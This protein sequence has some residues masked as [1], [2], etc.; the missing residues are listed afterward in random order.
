MKVYLTIQGGQ[1]IKSSNKRTVFYNA[2]DL[3]FQESVLVDGIQFAEEQIF[4]ARSN[5]QYKL[6]DR[7]KN[8]MVEVL[9]TIRKVYKN[10]FA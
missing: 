10:K 9:H 4:N 2:Q 5:K 8:K 3:L 1:E 7:R 6:W